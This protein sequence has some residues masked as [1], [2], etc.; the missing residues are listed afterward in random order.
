ML[1][2][3]G[4][5]DDRVPLAD[6]EAA[7]NVWIAKNGCTTTTVNAVQA[8][9]VVYQDCLAGYPVEWCTH[10]G[11]HLVPSFAADVI[12]EFFRAF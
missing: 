11:M 9:C 10:T 12:W 3:H 5:D 1:G 2:I 6:G 7:R 4:V 8:G